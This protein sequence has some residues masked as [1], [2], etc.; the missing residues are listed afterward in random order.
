[1]IVE[2]VNKRFENAYHLGK[3]P[4]VDCIVTSPPYNIKVSYE[5]VDDNLLFE[6]YAALFETWLSLMKDSLKPDG[7]LFLNYGFKSSEQWKLPWLTS[8]LRHQFTIQNTIIWVKSII[9]PGF[10][11]CDPNPDC[12][13][14]HCKPVNSDRYLN[15]LHE[16]VFHLTPEGH[17]PLEKRHPAVGVPYSDPSNISRFQQPN[18]RVYV[19][20]DHV[21]NQPLRDRGNV[22]F[23]P[24]VTKQAASGHPCPFPEQ[25]VAQCLALANV[26]PGSVVMDPFCGVGTVGLV[27]LDFESACPGRM[28]ITFIGI[29]ASQPYAKTAVVEILAKDDLYQYLKEKNN[30]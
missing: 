20:S 23:I 22:W 11:Y 21:A 2:I 6:Q 10:D 3:T 7:H 27:A 9:V 28:P 13:L 30:V 5:G 1:M 8:L 25:L 19:N 26:G 12:T 15:N 29:E 17:S 4:K 24:Y 18:R 14:G 16:F